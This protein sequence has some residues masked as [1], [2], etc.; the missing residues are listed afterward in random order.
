[1]SA[2]ATDILSVDLTI[3][4]LG[5]IGLHIGADKVSLLGN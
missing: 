2:N 5:L 3:G 4:S 1:M